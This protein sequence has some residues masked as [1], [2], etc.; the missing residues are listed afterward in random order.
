MRVSTTMKCILVG[1]KG[2]GKT[3]FLQH[4]VTGVYKDD[5]EPTQGYQ[6]CT[7]DFYTSIGPVWIDVWDIQQEDECLRELYYNDADCA[8]ICFDLTSRSSLQNVPSWKSEIT[9][10]CGDIPIAICKTKSDAPREQQV[11]WIE[12]KNYIWDDM[13]SVLL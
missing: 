7:L 11:S 6:V 2:T 4:H 9:R 12:S 5:C 3:S 1:D 10:I 8:I 13:V